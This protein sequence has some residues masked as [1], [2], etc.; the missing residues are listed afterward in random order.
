MQLLFSQVTAFKGN[1]LKVSICRRSGSTPDLPHGSKLCL[2]NKIFH[3]D[4]KGS[5]DVKNRFGT[6]S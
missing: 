6:K 4:S 3:D 5:C 2:S 1:L